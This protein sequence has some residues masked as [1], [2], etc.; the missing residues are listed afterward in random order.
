MYYSF[1]SIVLLQKGDNVA[2]DGTIMQG[3]KYAGYKVAKFATEFSNGTATY[4][5][6]DHKTYDKL[7]EHLQNKVLV[8]LIKIESINNYQNRNQNINREFWTSFSVLTL[9]QFS[10]FRISFHSQYVVVFRQQIRFH[11]EK[12]VSIVILRFGFQKNRVLIPR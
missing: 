9:S 5:P 6:F 11:C 8:G 12:F 1:I 2:E 3:S 10:F 4:H 7:Q